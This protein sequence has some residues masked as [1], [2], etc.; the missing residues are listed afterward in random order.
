MDTNRHNKG[1]GYEEWLYNNEYCAKRLSFRAGGTT[2]LHYHV[3]KTETFIVVKGT[4]S[5]MI[6]NPLTATATTRTMCVGDFQNVPVGLA[7]ALKC[8]G[9][10]GGVVIE[11]STHHEDKDSYR[12]APG[13]SQK[14]E[15]QAK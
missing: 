8:T 7:H 13:D 1:W 3:K 6:V 2:S 15:R 12:V 9:A 10:K 11:A 4:F 5:L 14:L